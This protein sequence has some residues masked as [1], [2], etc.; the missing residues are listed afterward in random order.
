MNKTTAVTRS[1]VPVL[2]L[3]GLACTASAAS[4]FKYDSWQERRLMEPNQVERKHESRG[5]VFIYD[6][7]EADK[8]DRA[9]DENFDRIDNM[10]FTRVHNPPPPG[11]DE[12]VVL[13]DGCE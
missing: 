6:G 3:A 13:D 10:M 2:F 1:A 12:P 5:K 9:M 4:P 7:L 11:S 8:I